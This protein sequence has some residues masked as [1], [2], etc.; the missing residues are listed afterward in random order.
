MGRRGSRRS[1]RAAI[2]ALLPLALAACPG[3]T[4]AP[5]PTPS[6]T[7]SAPGPYNPLTMDELVAQ[8]AART[9]QRLSEAEDFRIIVTQ[10][11][12]PVGTLMRPGSTIPI[13]YSACLPAAAPPMVP[14]PSLFPSYRLTRETGASVGLDEAVLQGIASA[15]LAVDRGNAINLSFAKSAL[16][17]LSDNDIGQI[18]A[19]PGCAALLRDRAVWLVR[20]YVFGQR[21]FSL[22]LTQKNEGALAVTKVANF[23]VKLANGGSSVALSDAE[24]TGFLQIVSELRPAPVTPPAPPPDTPPVT[25]PTPTNIAFEVTP[26][27]APRQPGRIYIQRDTAD[28]SGKAAALLAALDGADLP[29]VEPR[30]EAIASDKMPRL[31]QVRYFNGDDALLAETALGVLQRFFPQAKLVQVPLP[32]PRGQLEIWLPRGGRTGVDPLA[33]RPEIVA[34]KLLRARE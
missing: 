3:P 16:A 19:T 17:T 10:A 5:T 25:L 33:L 11:V 26:I 8:L 18:T 14:V 27:R 20:G 22:D 34:T 13:D 9:R 31:A 7:A 29:V 12:Y 2:A 23:D 28:R 21:T 30:I 24:P 15:R 6:T 32:S 1:A 4:P